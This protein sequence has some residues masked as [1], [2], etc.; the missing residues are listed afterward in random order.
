MGSWVWL[1]RESWETWGIG[2]RTSCAGMCSRCG[3]P[4][5]QLRRIQKEFLGYIFICR[6]FFLF[7]SLE[8]TEID[9]FRKLCFKTVLFQLLV[10]AEQYPQYG[11]LSEAAGSCSDCWRYGRINP[12]RAHSLAPVLDSSQHIT[13]DQAVTRTT[14]ADVASTACNFSHLIG[15]FFSEQNGLALPNSH[16]PGGKGRRRRKLSFTCALVY[17]IVRQRK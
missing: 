7:R 10:R 16:F 12:V 2:Q 8:G 14:K 11:A 5:V 17:N 6:G 13:L 4:S 9:Y 1:L 3:V 15:L